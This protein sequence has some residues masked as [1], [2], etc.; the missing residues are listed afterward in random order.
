MRSIKVE[1][2][3]GL[4]ECSTNTFSCTESFLPITYEFKTGKIYG[5][6]S[7]FGCGSWGLVSAVTGNGEWDSN[8]KVFIDNRLTSKEELEVISG[9]VLK[10]VWHDFFEDKNKCTVRNCIEFA[11]QISQQDYTHKE[12]K[13]IFCLTDA[14]YDRNMDFVSGE[15]WNISLAILFALNKNIIAYPWLNSIDVRRLSFLKKQGVL[16]FLKKQNKILLLPSS[17]TSSL[18]SLCDKRILFKISS[19]NAT[20]QYR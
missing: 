16:D 20:I 3:S 18:N 11:L 9:T 4:I 10:P 5:I 7:D 15:I 6:I 1:N 8:S 19:K 12:I 13:D 17:P 2:F 14:R